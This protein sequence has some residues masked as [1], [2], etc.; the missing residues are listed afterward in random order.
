[1]AHNIN[2][3]IGRQSA[4]HNLGTVTGS[5]TTWNEILDDG[6]LDFQV[7]KQ[8]LFDQFGNKLDGAY[9]VFRYDTGMTKAGTFLGQ[10]GEGY[11]TIDHSKGFEM[12]DSLMDT[13]DGAHYETAGVLGKGEVVWGL[14]D[15][16]LT[17]RVGDDIQ[18]GY[19]L[20]ATG[21]TGNM[22]HQYR[23]CMERVVCQN[24]LNIALTQGAK[25]VFRVKHTKN[26]T[27][28]LNNAHEA[29]GMLESD[30]RTMEQK[31]NF[32]T[33]RRVT[34]ESM[35]SILDRLFPKKKVENGED[36]SSTRRENI[37]AE[38]MLTY[39]DNDGNTFPEQRGTAY[40]LLNAI[41]NYTDHQRSTKGDM[42][43]ESALFGS[44]D[45]LKGQAYEIIMEGAGAMPENRQYVAASRGYS[46]EG[47]GLLG[48]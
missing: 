1:M 40:N 20:F 30:V 7:E 22:Q 42:R 21:H 31:L 27:L 15:L 46:L 5:Y 8:P 38:I 44:G 35:V 47:T 3:Y 39:E 14:A 17:A 24:T 2:T 28:K 18:Q 34:K 23:I 45:K 4:W 9:G 6:G 16:G 48:M 41:T 11:Q 25:N 36:E 37:L 19:L 43:S 10:V 33:T 32:L 12:I 13:S 26:A 29:L